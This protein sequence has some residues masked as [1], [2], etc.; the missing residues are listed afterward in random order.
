MRK[1][2]VIVLLFLS[3][4]FLFSQNLST[5]KGL[6]SDEKEYGTNGYD[7]AYNVIYQYYENEKSN[8]RIFNGFFKINHKDDNYTVTVN[9][10]FLE[11]KRNGIWEIMQSGGSPRI[12]EATCHYPDKTFNTH[13]YNTHAEYLNGKLNGKCS[14]KVIKKENKKTIFTSTAIFENNIMIGNYSYIDMENNIN[15]NCNFD[16]DGL[17]DGNYIFE[18]GDYKDIRKYEHGV[19]KTRLC[20]DMNSGKI[21]A[22]YDAEN[23]IYN[24][25][26][27]SD[28]FPMERRWSLNYWIIRKSSDWQSCEYVPAVGNSDIYIIQK[29]IDIEGFYT[30]HEK[31]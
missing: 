17:F 1:I 5:F 12:D 3:P 9:G 14:V 29:G 25:E 18:Y 15:L 6:Y 19:L 13:V 30:T 16:N 22:K 28:L 23:Q 2:I 8:E 20:R 31:P 24:K 27:H 7:K 21:Y 11:N 10:Q 4:I 26:E